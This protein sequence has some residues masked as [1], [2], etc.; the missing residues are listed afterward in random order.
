MV[1]KFEKGK[2]MP[3]LAPQQQKRHIH[4]KKEERVNIDK[5]IEYARSVFLNAKRSHIKNDTGYK[6]GDKHNSRVNSN[7]KELIKFTKDNFYQ[8]KSKASTTLTILL[9]L[10]L[11]MFLICLIMILMHLMFL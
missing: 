10:I 6:S 2:T 9:M 11:L 7:G 3:K 8:D 4:H 5:K 1:N